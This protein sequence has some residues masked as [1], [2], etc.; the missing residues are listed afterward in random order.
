MD[1]EIILPY[2]MKKSSDT[3]R[4]NELFPPALAFEPFYSHPMD[5]GVATDQKHRLKMIK[6][7]MKKVFKIRTEKRSSTA[8]K[9]DVP[10]AAKY[11]IKIAYEVLV[12]SE[13]EKGCI[14]N[15]RFVDLNEM[16]VW[17]STELIVVKLSRTITLSKKLIMTIERS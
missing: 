10:P 2:T 1:A 6:T 17:I 12:Y 8:L 4:P 13:K 16:R 7:A 5:N 11:I 15:L 3:L 14:S 9:P